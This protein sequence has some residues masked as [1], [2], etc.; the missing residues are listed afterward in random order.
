MEFEDGT[1]ASAVYSGADHFHT[2]ELAFGIGEQGQRVDPTAYGRAR[3]TLQK[4]GSRDA[5][6]GLKRAVRY[7]GD[8]APRPAGAAPPPSL[9]G[10]PLLGWGE[11]GNPPSAPGGFGFGGKKGPWGTAL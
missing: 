9:F 7:G 8:R 5:E 11:G 3:Q 4:V 10:L 1:P 6:L 2:T